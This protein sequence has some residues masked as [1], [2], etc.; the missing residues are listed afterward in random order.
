MENVHR[1]KGS[2]SRMAKPT[3]FIGESVQV[4]F[5]TPPVYEKKP[6]CPDGFLWDGR[7]YRVV[8]LLQAWVDFSRRGR[9]KRNMQPQHASVASHR[10]SWGVGR[11]FFQ[12]KVDTGQQFELYYDRA[13][14]DVDARKGA[15]F[16][17][18]EYT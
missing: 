3:R 17:V 6:E 14:K 18:A 10:G 12:V 9:M 7:T 15:W 1:S 8:E 4:I 16:L 5:D 13:P 11:F 2:F